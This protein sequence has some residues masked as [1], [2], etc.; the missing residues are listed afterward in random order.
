VLLGTQPTNR[1]ATARA[2]VSYS[3]HDTWTPSLQVF[4]TTGTPDPVQYGGGVR[5]SGYI[6]ELAYTPWGK[7]D[8]P[9]NWLNVRTAVQYMHY[10]EFDGDHSHAQDN[11]SLYFSAWLALAPLGWKVQR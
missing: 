4:T 11:D 9:F 2:D 8:S 3:F 7:A 1:L 5:T 10:V 6:A